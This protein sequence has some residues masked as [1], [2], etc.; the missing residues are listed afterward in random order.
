[1][2]N[3]GVGLSLQSLPGKMTRQAGSAPGLDPAQCA[4]LRGCRFPT[5]RRCI[6][7]V[8]RACRPV[9]SIQGVVVGRISSYSSFG[10]DRR[11]KITLRIL[12]AQL[13]DLDLAIRL[14]VDFPDDGRRRALA[15]PLAPRL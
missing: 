3:S 6:P 8:Q 15:A 9:F 10:D 13:N 14:A 4:V 7:L 11:G 5:G 12:A 1:L 2:R